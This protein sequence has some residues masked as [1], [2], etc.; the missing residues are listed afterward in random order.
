[1]FTKH[2]K[3]CKST[4]R[5]I[6]RLSADDVF[7][8]ASC[9]NLG[10]LISNFAQDNEI[11]RK[12]GC[13]N[14]F[15]FCV[16]L[17]NLPPFKRRR[18]STFRR[19]LWLAPNE[20]YPNNDPTSSRS[21]RRPVWSSSDSHRSQ[22]PPNK[23]LCHWNTMIE[24]LVCKKRKFLRLILTR[25]KIRHDHPFSAKKHLPLI[26]AFCVR[27]CLKYFKIFS[28]SRKIKRSLGSSAMAAAWLRRGSGITAVPNKSASRTFSVPKI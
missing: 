28:F 1:M 17:F 4:H 21:Y 14:N 27:G 11:E 18:L 5:T 19:S 6:G 13:K 22:S 12:Q 16:L 8:V 10:N 24:L 9:S 7:L 15:R 20:H 2:C 26:T 23:M 25:R 3:Q